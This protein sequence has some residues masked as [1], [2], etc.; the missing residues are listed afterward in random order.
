MPSLFF[1]TQEIEETGTAKVDIKTGLAYVGRKHG[2]KEVIWIKLKE[3]KKKKPP[4]EMME[5][6]AE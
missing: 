4:L 1:D 5:Y 6:K 2:D 3:C